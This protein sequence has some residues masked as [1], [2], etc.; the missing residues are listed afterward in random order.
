VR[1]LVARF[2]PFFFFAGL[3][4]LAINFL[5]LAPPLYMLQVFD[6]VITSRSQETLFV[7]TVAVVA[8]LAVM[9]LLDVLRTRLLGATGAALDRRLGPRVLDA[10]LARTAQLSGP[11]YVNGLAALSVDRPR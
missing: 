8:A 6:R 9:A 2:K 1:D 11:E 3:F 7:L 4:S 10:L 5:L